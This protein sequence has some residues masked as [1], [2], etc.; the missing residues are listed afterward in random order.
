MS[1]ECVF[2]ILALFLPTFMVI[3]MVIDDCFKRRS[4][5]RQEERSKRFAEAASRYRT[6]P[7]ATIVNMVEHLEAKADSSEFPA[8]RLAFRAKAQAIRDKHGF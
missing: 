1:P 5:I 7:S 8:E 4:R 6:A 3:K 2:L